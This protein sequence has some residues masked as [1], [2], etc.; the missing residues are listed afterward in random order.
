M[1]V[2]H[3]SELYHLYSTLQQKSTLRRSVFETDTENPRDYENT[4]IF[5]ATIR[6]VADNRNYGAPGD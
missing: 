4:H 5:V 1:V 3:T 6:V 2:R